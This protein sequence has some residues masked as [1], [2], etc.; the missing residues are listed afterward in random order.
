MC[1][2][3]EAHPPDKPA[4]DPAGEQMHPEALVSSADVC[5]CGHVQFGECVVDHL[6]ILIIPPA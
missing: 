5:H 2:Q 4:D 6:E 3:R 1:M